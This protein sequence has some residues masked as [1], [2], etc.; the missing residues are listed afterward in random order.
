MVNIVRSAR[1]S[2][3]E[4]EI[5]SE[6]NVSPTGGEED[7]T[8]LSLLERVRLRDQSAWD[9]LVRLYTPL[10]ELWCRRMGLRGSDVDDVRQEVFLAVSR[11][12]G[13]FQR[14]SG[15]GVFRGWLRTITH[16]KVVDLWRQRQTDIPALGGSEGYEQMQKVPEKQ[17]NEGL[18]EELRLLY[19]RALDLIAAD[20]GEKVIRAFWRVVVDGQRALQVAGELN[21][22]RDAV[23]HAKGRVLARLREEFKG[24]IDQ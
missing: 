6:S 14:K 21:M 7:R 15:K 2:L 24:L 8:S 1:K 9:R 12:I 4:T 10:V 3:P 11:R 23:Y 13:R 22:T 19:R 5:M 20:F 18:R 16:N 17:S